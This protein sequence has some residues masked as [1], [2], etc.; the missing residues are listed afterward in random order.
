MAR[1]IDVIGGVTL[2]SLLLSYVLGW[3]DPDSDSSSSR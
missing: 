2:V 3:L 1:A